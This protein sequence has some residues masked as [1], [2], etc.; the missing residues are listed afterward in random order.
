MARTSRW[1]ENERERER[2]RERETGEEEDKLGIHRIQSNT[3]HNTNADETERTSTVC[4]AAE[5]AHE[6][7]PWA[8]HETCPQRCVA[9]SMCNDVSRVC[10]WTSFNNNSRL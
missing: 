9:G 4:A 8:V 6:L 3:R 2:E 5:S 1:R 10:S 7:R